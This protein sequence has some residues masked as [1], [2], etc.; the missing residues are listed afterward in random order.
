MQGLTAVPEADARRVF[1]QMMVAV[2]YCHRLG[3]ANRDIK[4]RARR[5]SDV[6]PVRCIMCTRTHA[7]PLAARHA[8]AAILSVF[9]LNSCVSRIPQSAV[10]HRQIAAHKCIWTGML[11]QSRTSC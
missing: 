2:D 1:Q 7:E 6:S 4:V 8:V 3:I 10:L 9:L 5:S 11:C